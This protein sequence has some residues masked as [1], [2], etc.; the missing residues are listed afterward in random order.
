MTNGAGAPAPADALVILGIS[1][2]DAAN[3]LVAGFIPRHKPSLDDT[4]GS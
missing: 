3:R 2:P 4:S 1:G